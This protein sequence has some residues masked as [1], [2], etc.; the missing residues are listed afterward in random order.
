MAVL[1]FEDRD[2]EF[3]Q[4]PY[5]IHGSIGFPVLESLGRITFHV[6][7][8][9]GVQETTKAAGVGSSNLYLEHFTILIQANVADEDHLMT[10]DTGAT[11]TF[12]SEQY[13]QQHRQDFNSENLREFEL[14]GVGGSTVL[15]AYVQPN[16]R[17]KMGGACVVLK[18]LVVLTEPTG[19]PDE[20]SGNVGQSIVGLFPSYTIDFQTMTLSAEDQVMTGQDIIDCSVH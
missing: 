10:L 7:G 2:L 6:N 16:V 11:G 18:N 8:K 19:L 17:F 9:F 20:L 12:M 13:Y 5:E 4:I 15:P 3:P 14:V 1:V